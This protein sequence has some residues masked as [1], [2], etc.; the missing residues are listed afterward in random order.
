MALVGALIGLAGLVEFVQP[1]GAADFQFV[2]DQDSAAAA[3]EPDIDGVGTRTG[4]PRS[5]T[6]NLRY[7]H[8]T[9]EI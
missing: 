4:T 9:G 7:E 6:A 8:T 3:S 1:V 5:V 2:A